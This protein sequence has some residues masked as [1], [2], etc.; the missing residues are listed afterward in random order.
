ME[1][2]PLKRTLDASADL[3][4]DHTVFDRR[5][6]DI[7]GHVRPDDQGLVTMAL[8]HVYHLAESR[9]T[10]WNPAVD[11]AQMRLSPEHNI[12]G[13]NIVMGDLTPAQL[14]LPM[15]YTVLV[16][17]PANVYLL[18]SD[19]AR[20]KLLD[21]NAIEC[22][23]LASVQ[24]DVRLQLA[25]KIWSCKSVVRF[26]P[27]ATEKHVYSFIYPDPITAS[28]PSAAAATTG[29]APDGTGSGGFL[30]SL[31]RGWKG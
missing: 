6:P 2:R 21:P 25:I 31:F 27:A 5:F 23:I 30:Q 15:Y 26:R 29:T 9:S 14:E 22:V 19:L 12:L 16:R 7:A 13:N 11:V 8:N 3:G 1:R 17:L 4:A 20:L 10:N 24:T 18:D 28:R